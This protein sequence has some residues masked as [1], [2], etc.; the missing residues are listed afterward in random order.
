ME[1]C[2]VLVCSSGRSNQ[3]L[4]VA[5]YD[6][7]GVTMVQKYEE[8]VANMTKPLG[9]TIEESTDKARLVYITSVG[10]KVLALRLLLLSTV[11]SL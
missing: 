2:I 1:L 10:E 3:L 5:Y 6:E 11:L 8:I 9:I 4:L 7:T